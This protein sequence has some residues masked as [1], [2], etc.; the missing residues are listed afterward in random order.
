MIH[1]NSSVVAM[2]NGRNYE[3]ATG[4][5]GIHR[6]GGEKECISG[7]TTVARQ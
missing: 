3:A 4:R 5:C 7:C 6:E 2:G 1:K